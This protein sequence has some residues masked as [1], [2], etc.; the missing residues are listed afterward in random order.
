MV[1][2]NDVVELLDLSE[3]ILCIVLRIV[4][5]DR[6]GVTELMSSTTASVIKS[7]DDPFRR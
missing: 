5:L 2:L 1:L 6:R 3:L 7:A 4:V